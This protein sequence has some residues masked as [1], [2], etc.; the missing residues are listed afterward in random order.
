MPAN[1]L[2]V[3]ENRGGHSEVLDLKLFVIFRR[4]CLMNITDQN[5]KTH[6]NSDS[7]KDCNE[8]HYVFL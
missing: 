1:A 5:C 8:N 2:F 7:Y 6:S 4:Y 3:A